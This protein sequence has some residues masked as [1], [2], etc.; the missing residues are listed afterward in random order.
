MGVTFTKQ[1]SRKVYTMGCGSWAY[2]VPAKLVP[3]LS[4]HQLRP[5]CKENRPAR[6]LHATTDRLY[7]TYSVDPSVQFGSR[8]PFPQSGGSRWRC[9]SVHLWSAIGGTSIIRHHSQK[10]GSWPM[11]SVQQTSTAG[12]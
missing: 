3:P 1:S 2:G 5:A 10:W 9:C 7:S 11:A 4:R 6:R 8:G 12:L